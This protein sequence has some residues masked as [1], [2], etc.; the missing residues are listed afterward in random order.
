MTKTDIAEKTD[1]TETAD[2]TKTETAEQAKLLQLPQIAGGALAAVTSAAVGAQL[3]VAGTL[4][5]AAVAS[6]LAAV[7]GAFYTRGLEHTRD[8]VKKIVLR[9]AEGDTEV[10]YVPDEGARESSAQT[11]AV[12]VHD[13]T[14]AKGRPAGPSRSTGSTGSARSAKRSGWSSPWAVVGGMVAT[15]AVTFVVAMGLITGWE[16]TSGQ[17]LGGNDGTTIGQVS[18]RRSSATPTPSAS[19]SASASASV[20]PSATSTPTAT[21][22]PTP[23]ETAT[24]T[25]T[26]TPSAS[27]TEQTPATTTETAPGSE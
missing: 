20:T 6:V 16:F 7:A 11:T 27:E 10:L 24:P 18:N 26:A 15:A 3:G 8:G 5:G 4:V 17:S 22:T 12:P 21:P 19:A 9:D 1:K 25:A 14:D 13:T 2:K 23:T